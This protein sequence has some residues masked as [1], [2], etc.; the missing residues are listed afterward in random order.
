MYG[1]HYLPHDAVDAIVH[2]KLANGDKSS[3]IEM[4]LRGAGLQVRV[5]PKLFVADRLNKARTILPLCRF[6]EQKC[7][8][9]LRQMRL[10]QWGPKTE[11]GVSRREPLHDSA[12][13]P[14]DA[15]CTAAVCA[16]QPGPDAPPEKPKSPFAQTSVANYSPYA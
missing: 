12:S 13:H 15:F 3:S 10:Y 16:K 14:A 4:I 1:E 5:A 7:A 6:D 11:L 8:E 9:G 2:N